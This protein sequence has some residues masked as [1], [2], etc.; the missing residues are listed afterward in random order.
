MHWENQGVAILGKHASLAFNVAITD[1]EAATIAKGLIE[2]NRTI[3]QKLIHNYFNNIGKLEPIELKLNGRAGWDSTI[4]NK[5]SAHI[6]NI[7]RWET[8]VPQ[9]ID[10]T[11]PDVTFYECP[12]CSK[13]EPSSCG[14]FQLD[15]LDKKQK[16][17]L[18]K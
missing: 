15:D 11:Q 12:R 18:C 1:Q 4:P 2:L 16:C 10:G 9:Q 13:V 5:P 3:P 8:K 7:N 6:E 14:S 17:K